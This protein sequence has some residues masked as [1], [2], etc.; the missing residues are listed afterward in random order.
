MQLVREK[1]RVKFVSKR[2]QASRVVTTHDKILPD[3]SKAA[4]KASCQGFESSMRGQLGFPMKQ[5]SELQVSLS[6][7]H[8]NFDSIMS[9]AQHED[10]EMLSSSD[11]RESPLKQSAC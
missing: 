6:K 2:D 1:R 5:F 10:A 11:L 4:C 9:G 3:L 8:Q 7:L